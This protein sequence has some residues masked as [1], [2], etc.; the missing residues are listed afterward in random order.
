MK[1]IAALLFSTALFTSH[2]QQADSPKLVIG[3]VVDQMCYEYLY[4]YYDKFCDGGFRKLMENGTNCRNTMY[5][6]IPTYT[7]PGHA[8]IYTG[9][10]PSNH[11]I[12]GNDWF[13][14]AEWASVNCV[15]DTTVR[16]VGD[17]SSYGKY[18]P[19][20]LKANTITDQ[21]KLTYPEAKV[22]SMSIKNRGAILPGGHMSDGSYWYDYSSG[23]FITS[24]FFTDALPEWVN[25]FNDKKYA[26]KYLKQVWE[27]I[28]PLEA[29]GE[30]GPDDSPYEHLLPGKETPTFPY[31][32]KAMTNDSLHYSLFTSTPFANTFLTDLA[33]ASLENEELGDDN[34]TDMLCISYS[35]PDIIGHA[36]GPYS[37]EIEDTY[38][39]LDLELKR[40]MKAIE[41]KVGDDDY[42]LFLT[43]DHAVVPVPQYLTDKKLPGGYFFIDE[44]I[45][46]L[47][48]KLVLKYGVNP[49]IYEDNL[50]LYLD[51]KLM[52]DSG[53]DA[54]EVRTYIANE[55]QQWEGVKRSFTSEQLY[56]AA[57]D[58][59]WMDMVRKGVH[60]EESGDV[61]FILEP[62]YLPK[63]E[64]T[65]LTRKGTSHGSA[66]GYDTHVPLLWY[67]KS[68]PQQ[69]I[70]REIQ[71]TDISA[72]LTHLLYLQRPNALTGKPILEL[73]ER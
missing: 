29:Y 73:L 47:V 41:D 30:S 67:G 33:I 55:V 68:V 26:D 46:A 13:S 1:L 66:F 39:R 57:V 34:Q 72:T 22:I 15:E 49:I 8:S 56:S 5:N 71:I 3:I 45:T 61:M 27:P 70:F 53:I 28:M 6:Y 35:T 14:R 2:A 52:H 11:G 62:G 20:R 54:K 36:F 51:R 7:G 23:K 44:H 18:S 32:L 38:I 60:H 9:T 63:S 19:H 31:D 10:T 50:N 58:A 12:V 4:R 25:K 64:E 17:T 43:A 59:E 16:T 21:L 42:V 37:I 69:E 24:T 48:R 40:L 65:E